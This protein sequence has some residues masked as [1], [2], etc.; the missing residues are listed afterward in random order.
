MVINRSNYQ[1]WFLD[2]IDGSLNEKEKL[3]VEKFLEENPGL[4][5]ELDSLKSLKLKPGHDSFPGKESVIKSVSDYTDIQFENLCIASLEN[6]LPAGQISEFQEMIAADVQKKKMFELY[7][8]LKLRPLPGSYTGKYQLRKLTTG[9]KI[10]RISL[11]TSAIAASIAV[12]T[13]AYMFL[14]GSHNENPF[15]TSVNLP[16]DTL[17]I[18]KGTV[19]ESHDR[20]A[21]TKHVVSDQ[22]MLRTGR[23]SEINPDN[24][25]ADEADLPDLPLKT[26]KIERL[27]SPSP[28]EVKIPDGA[29]IAYIPNSTELVGR[30]VQ[31]LPSFFY[32]RR[33][34][35]DRFLAKFFHERIMNE[36]NLGD[37]PVGSIEIAE[38]G[39]TGI[40][41]LLGWDMELQKKTDENGIITS[42]YF[43]SRLLKFN[44]PVKKQVKE[45]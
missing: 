1:I 36:K 11:L 8:R 2:L 41:K 26:D 39:I 34:N 7:S 9:Q 23:I 37:K 6:D 32:D 33:S 17:L 14:T 44:T 45:L 13:I 12:L 43:S 25:L 28:L 10:F 4:R 16:P 29:I 5:T 27:D 40:N 42:Y 31:A 15:R 20:T 18:N 24:L 21:S 38:A 30:R 19:I 3:E 22:G 35:V